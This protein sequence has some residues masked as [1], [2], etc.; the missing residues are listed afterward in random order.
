MHYSSQFAVKFIDVFKYLE[1][2]SHVI[3]LSEKT[4][5]FEERKFYIDRLLKVFV[6][7]LFGYEVTT[8]KKKRKQKKKEKLGEQKSI[9]KMFFFLFL[10]I[11]VYKCAHTINK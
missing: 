8:K 6:K 7:S 10:T 3:I 9:S 11:D 2:F 5:F 4:F 1:K